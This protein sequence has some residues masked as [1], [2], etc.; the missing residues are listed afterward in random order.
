MQMSRDCFAK[1]FY[2]F[3]ESDVSME[4][5]APLLSADLTGYHAEESCNLKYP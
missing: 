3:L 4:P 5:K 1:E 2:C